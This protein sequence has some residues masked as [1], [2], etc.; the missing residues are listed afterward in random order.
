MCKHGAFTDK[1]ERNCYFAPPGQDCM[2]HRQALQD[3]LDT[4]QESIHKS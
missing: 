2:I 1:A 4:S 3:Y